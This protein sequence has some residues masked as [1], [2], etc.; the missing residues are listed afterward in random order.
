MFH[1]IPESSSRE[2]LLRVVELQLN[3]VRALCA[4]PAGSTVDKSWLCAVWKD[5]DCAWVRKFWE[6][7][8]GKRATWVNRL[9]RATLEEKR[10]VLQI[11]DGQLRF[12]E[13]WSSTPSVRMRRIQ[14]NREPFHA[15]NELL[16]SFYAPL[17]YRGRGYLFENDSFDKDAFLAG[18][19]AS[20]RKVCPYCDNFLQ[21]T[22]LDHFLP[23]D[24]FPFLSCHPDNLIPSCHDS[25]SGSHKGTIVPLDWGKQDQA[26]GW[27]HPR[28]RSAKGR[29]R[30]EVTETPLRCLCARL[31]PVDE[32]DASRVANLDNA[33]KVSKFWSQQIEDELQL[34]GNQVSDMLRE[35]NLQPTEDAVRSRLQILATEKKAEIGKRGLAICHHALYVFAADTPA[36]V[37]DIAR[38]CRDR[39]SY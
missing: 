30:V 14:W 23:K 32:V 37:S 18:M 1:L 12:Q 35:D 10:E 2:R 25:N 11:T 22:E 16:K 17:F 3:L 20:K 21:K 15:L 26:S 29:V 13:L 33:F 9:A 38:E 6:N 5:L 8:S 28:W 24:E 34:I 39:I 27:F 7:D 31:L 36:I 4:L 19:A